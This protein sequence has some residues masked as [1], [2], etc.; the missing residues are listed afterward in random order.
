MVKFESEIK[1]RRKSPVWLTTNNR[2]HLVSMQ[3][4]MILNNCD[5]LHGMALFYSTSANK[6]N[7]VC[8][9]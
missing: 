9:I 2:I 3:V 5:L 4:I 8:F 7:K 1:S 6:Q